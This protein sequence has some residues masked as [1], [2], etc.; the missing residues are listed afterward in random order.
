M[1][2][3]RNSNRY[4]RNA[5][6]KTG[7][8]YQRDEYGPGSAGVRVT[9]NP[10]LRSTEGLS[11]LGCSRQL[12][13]E[14]RFPAGSDVTGRTAVEGPDD[15]ELAMVTEWAISRSLGG[16]L[17]QN[18]DGILMTTQWRA[19]LRTEWSFYIRRSRRKG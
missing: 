16:I 14:R 19:E 15:G 12:C 10:V 11:I 8:R 1:C 3:V 4:L 6:N 9:I 7:W 5:D 13:G 17:Q 2:H 18:R